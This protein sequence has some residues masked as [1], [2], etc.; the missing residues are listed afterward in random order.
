M[1]G[2]VG[3]A[4]KNLWSAGQETMNIG[5]IRLHNCGDRGEQSIPFRALVEYIQHNIYRLRKFLENLLL[6][7]IS[8]RL[9][10]RR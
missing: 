10:K 5:Q 6:R 2:K 8:G 4:P 1:F 7:R 9:V 3:A